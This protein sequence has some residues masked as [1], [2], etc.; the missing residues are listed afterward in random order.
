MTKSVITISVIVLSLLTLAFLTLKPQTFK[1]DILLTQTDLNNLITQIQTD[2]QP[3]GKYKYQPPK[4]LNGITYQVNEYETPKGEYGYW[5]VMK[6]IEQI[7]KLN[8][9]TSKSELVDKVLTKSIGYGVD[10]NNLTY[11]WR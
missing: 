1:G 10:I 7:S 2:L 4:T 11:D 8:A 3:N 5:I 6:K 9:T